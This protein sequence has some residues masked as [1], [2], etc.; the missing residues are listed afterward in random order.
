[1][2]CKFGHL[3]SGMIDPLTGKLSEFD[4]GY[5]TGIGVAVLVI[6]I[7][8]LL[9][10][11]FWLLLRRHRCKGIE[12][13]EVNGPV[14]IS[15]EAVSDLIL[16][17]QPEFPDLTMIRIRL[18]R[19]GRIQQAE[20][21]VAFDTRNSGMPEQRL[22]LKERILEVLDGIMGITSLTEIRILCSAVKV[23]GPLPGHSTLNESEL[24]EDPIPQPYNL[25]PREE[26]K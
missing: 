13:K 12:I 25:P 2:D 21:Q 26:L 20:L 22:R 4:A 1:M 5:L 6:L 11:F 9:R 23:S 15:A 8:L 24:I 16:S 17:L 19:R 7:L 18:F 14:F 3:F 10:V